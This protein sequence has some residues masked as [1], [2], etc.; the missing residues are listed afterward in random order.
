MPVPERV[1][2]V[3]FAWALLAGNAPD[4]YLL[5]EGENVGPLVSR[6]DLD[7]CSRAG[8]KDEWLDV[9]T[10]IILDRKAPVWVFPVETVSLSEG[11]FEAVYQCTVLIPRWRLN[12]APGEEWSVEFKH[13]LLPA[14]RD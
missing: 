6:L 5:R 9:E 14:R 12:L 2:G 1:F 11:G 7:P 13:Q 10:G 8:A 3:G 4:R